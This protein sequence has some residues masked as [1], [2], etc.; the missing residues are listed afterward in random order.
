VPVL[1]FWDE[2][3]GKYVLLSAMGPAGPIGP[4]GAAGPT[5]PTGT[6]GDTGATGPVLANT[7]VRAYYGSGAVPARPSATYVEWVGASSPGANALT[8]DTWISTN[9]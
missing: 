7:V 9:P 5:G 4:V 3:Q 8:G 2:T 6:K 1:K